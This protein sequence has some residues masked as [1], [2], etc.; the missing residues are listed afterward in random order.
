MRMDASPN[1]TTIYWQ[2]AQLLRNGEPFD[3]GFR[4]YYHFDP[5]PGSGLHWI[6]YVMTDDDER[7]EIISGHGVTPDQAAGAAWYNLFHTGEE[8]PEWTIPDA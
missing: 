6:C 7:D 8:Y 5:T 2:L 4:I 3:D 1:C